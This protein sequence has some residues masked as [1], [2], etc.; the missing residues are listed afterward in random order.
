M[1]KFN[2]EDAYILLLILKDLSKDTIDAQKQNVKNY[3]SKLPNKEYISEY[4]RLRLQKAKNS[5]KTASEKI[6]DNNKMIA[7]LLADND[8][9]AKLPKDTI[10]I[11]E[12]TT[13]YTDKYAEGIDFAKKI[14]QEVLQEDITSKRMNNKLNKIAASKT[15]KQ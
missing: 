5:G 7:K 15:K 8:K 11:A 4:G 3:I 6:E 10:I 9:L 1:R 2:Q 13:L 12:D 14:I